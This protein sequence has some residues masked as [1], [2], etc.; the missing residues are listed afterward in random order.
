MGYKY[1]FVG[2]DRLLALR[3]ANY[4]YELFISS[5]DQLASR[6][7]LR[8]YLESQM[9]G[10]ESS[11]KTADHL[12]RLWLASQDPYASLRQTL[13]QLTQNPKP[14]LLARCGRYG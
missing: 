10:Q 4:S 9:A 3:W 1:I 13:A 5:Q 12:N 6:N 14:G 8:G 2:A 7:I 11:R